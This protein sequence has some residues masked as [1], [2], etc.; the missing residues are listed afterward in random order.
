[1]AKLHYVIR[2]VLSKNSAEM[3][4]QR[5]I[6]LAAVSAPRAVR[7]GYVTVFTVPS[8]KRAAVSGP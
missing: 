4:T 2:A 6:L 3:E 5:I 1:M 8:T 7:N